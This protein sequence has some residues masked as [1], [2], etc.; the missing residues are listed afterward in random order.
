MK[1]IKLKYMISILFSLFLV[2]ISCDDSNLNDEINKAVQANREI[3][4]TSEVVSNNFVGNGAQWGGYDL[5]QTWLGQETL[6]DADWNKLFERIDF[7]RPP[8]LRIMTNSG[9]SYDNNGTYDEVT[10]TKSLFKMLDYAQSRNIEITYGEWG[11]QSVGDISTIDMDWIANSVKFLN[12]LVNE[13]GY[14][15]IKTINIINEPNGSWA[16]TQGSYAIY[17]DV[18]IAYLAEM[19][20]Y[21]LSG[22]K[23]L[24]PDIAVFNTASQTEWIAN[25]HNDLGDNVGL[26]DIHVYPKQQLIRNGEFSDMLRAYKKVTPEGKQI[27]LGEIGFK[28]DEVDA[29]LKRLNEEAIANDPFA[30][31]D[32]NM[33]VYEAFYGI[34]M[35]DALIQTMREGFS[36]ALVWNMDDAMYNSPDNGDWQTTALKRWGFWNI[37][38]E[39]LTSNAADENI[40]PYFYP[41]SLLTRYFP[42]G[43]E[44]YN[45]KLPNK[46]GLRAVVGVYNGKYT[47]AIVNSHYTTYNIVLKSD[48]LNSLT[49]NKYT[50]KSNADGSFVG[51][52]DGNG[53][54]VPSENNVVLNFQEGEEM[55][56]Q[57]ESFVLFTNMD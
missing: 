47:V 39:E 2:L 27:V 14:T 34:D 36:G 7:M 44:I 21:D 50:Y 30:G 6:S 54:A 23:L 25:T 4:I 22:V 15:V 10:K 42:A 37:L 3:H 31:E 20:K 55:T 19:A 46:K 48:A 49:A 38:G 13:K 52:V 43:S 32:S 53:F 9:W 29:E 57:G 56:L 45:V 33:M 26:Y 28:Y 1:N 40:R 11:H 8:F 24:G 12:H 18:Q 41:V 5:V 51:E 35:A 17:K 16:S